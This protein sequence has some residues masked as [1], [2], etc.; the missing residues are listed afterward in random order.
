MPTDA[1]TRDAPAQNVHDTTG[2]DGADNEVSVQTE[3]QE[4]TADADTGAD[5]AAE[6]PQPRTA[7]AARHRT[8]RW[9]RVVA[10]GLLPALVMALAIAGGYLK[11]AATS[12][13]L[14]QAAAAESVQAA[15]DGTIALLSYRPDTVDKDLTSARGRLTG[16][17]ATDYSQLVNDVVIPGA[18][19]KSIAA[20]ASVPAAASIS[21]TPNHAVVLVFVNQTVT[22]G[23]DAPTSTASTGR[24]TLNKVDDKWLIS[25]FDPI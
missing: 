12:T 16:T 22:V 19:Q 24:V 8:R 6:D 9:T 25:A 7:P 17:F 1:D 21:S 4:G 15:T 5:A 10:Y 20:I 3:K 11:W 14:A 23:N 13:V 2:G 18:K